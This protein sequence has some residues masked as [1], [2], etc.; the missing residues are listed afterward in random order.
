MNLF[1]IKEKAK[2][3]TDHDMI[4]TYVT[5]PD[6]PD[7][8]I[9]LLYT[10]LSRGNQMQHSELYTLVTTLVQ[11]GLDTH[12]KI[13]P[14]GG[15]YAS[16]SREDRTR[17]LNVLAGDYLSGRFYQLL[18][19]AEQIETIKKLSSAICE[20]N[21][22]KLTLYM[23]MKQFKCSAEDYLKQTVFIKTHLFL[24]FSHW[25]SQTDR[26]RWADI[27]SAFTQCEVIVEELIKA[28]QST[29]FKEGWAY[30]FAL[31]KASDEERQQL[32]NEDK[33]DEQRVNHIMK[34]YQIGLALKQ[35]LQSNL[36]HLQALIDPYKMEPIALELSKLFKQFEPFTAPVKIAEQSS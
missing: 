17:Q 9:E 29:Q 14:T 21:R 24:S 10:F 16:D 13:E 1:Q 15:E 4:E 3:Y 12:D 35:L 28:Q 7:Q 22:T 25:F 31:Q 23:K 36:T 18:A 5:L 33:L 8:R 20:V 11:I 6:F 2:K 27:F 26:A 34:K 30:W 19:Q 32:I